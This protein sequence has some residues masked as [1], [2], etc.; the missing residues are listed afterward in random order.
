[1]RLPDNLLHAFREAYKADFGVP[2]AEDDVASSVIAL[3]NTF[4]RALLVAAKSNAASR[5]G[6]L[7][8]EVENKRHDD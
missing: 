6:G 8:D 1:M 5:I 4:G 2:P 3:L 7:L